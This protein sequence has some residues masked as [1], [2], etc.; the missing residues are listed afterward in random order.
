MTAATPARILIADDEESIRFVLREA[1]EEDGCEVIDVDNGDAAFD[2]LAAGEFQIAFVDIR[3]PGLT[4]LAVLDRLKRAGPPA[5][6]LA[7]TCHDQ[8]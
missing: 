5:A 4:G 1:L 6:V 3:L 2:A 8:F 7:L